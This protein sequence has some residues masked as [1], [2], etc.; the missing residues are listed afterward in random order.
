MSLYAILVYAVSVLAVM[1]GIA[2]YIGS[3]KSERKRMIWYSLLGVFGAVWSVSCVLFLSLPTDASEAMVIATRTGIYYGDAFMAIGIATFCVWREKWGKPLTI[4]CAL[5]MACF[6]TLLTVNPEIMFSGYTLSAQQGNS[7]ELVRGWAYFVYIMY[8]AVCCGAAILGTYMHS[9]RARQRSVKRGDYVLLGGMIFTSIFSLV[10]NAAFPIWVTYSLIWVGPLSLSATLITFYFA[11]LKFHLVSMESKWLKVLSSVVLMV[12]GAIIYMLIF[13]LIFTALF[14]IP[15]PSPAIL[16][17]NFL[18]IIIVLLLMPVLNE[19]SSQIK[20]LIAVGQVDLAYVVKKLNRV[21]TKNIDLRELAAFL[22]DHLH[23]SY[24]GFILNGR[25]YGSKTLTVTPAQLSQITHM[26][27]SGSDIWQQPN[28]TTQETLDEL[29]IKAVAELRNAKGRTFGQLVVGKPM[30]KTSFDRRDLIQI[31]MIINL[32]ATIID[33]EKH[34][35][36]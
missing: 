29:G 22:A 32:V 14:K 10:F 9:R 7:I 1:S 16:V 25:L 17:L 19:V 8:N 20:S 33:S 28:K 24:A 12:S 11:S 26:K 30:G 6:L 3:P 31:E 4:V 2:G 21:A 23:F 15:N 35:R 34:L 18:M 36:A 5:F 13:Y 27:A